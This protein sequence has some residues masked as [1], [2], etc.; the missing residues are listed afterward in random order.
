MVGYNEG[1]Y[2]KYQIFDW[3]SG[4]VCFNKILFDSESEAR[5]YIDDLA[6]CDECEYDHFQHYIIIEVV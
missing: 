6:A 1:G 3:K 4:E 5:N 2:M